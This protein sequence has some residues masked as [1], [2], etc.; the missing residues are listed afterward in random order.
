[1][2]KLDYA[3]VYTA[4]KFFGLLFVKSGMLNELIKNVP[5]IT[6]IQHNPIYGLSNLLINEDISEAS[7]S[8]EGNIAFDGQGVIVGIIGTGIDYLN[9]RFMKNTG[10][11]KIVAIWDQSIDN[12]PSSD[13]IPFGRE[14]NEEDINRAINNRAEG[15]DPYEVVPHKDEVGHGTAIAG[16]I[17]GRNFGREDKLK[18][19]APNCEFAIVKL[20]EAIPEITKLA[21]F[22]EDIKNLYLS[23]SIALAI[24]YLSDLQLKLKKLMVVYLP[25][26]TNFG[27]HEG[28]TILERYIEDITQRRDF[29][30]V[31]DTGDQGTGRTHTSGIIEKIGDTKDILFNIGQGQNSL[32]IGVYVRRIDAISISITAPSGDT[33]KNIPL[34]TVEEKNNYFN[35]QENNI[36]INYFANQTLTGLV[37]INIVIKNA[38]EGVW[39][40]SLLGEVIVSGLYDAWMPQAELL[41]GNTGFLNPVSNTTLLTPCAA[42]DIISTSYYNQIDNTV[43]ETS[44]KGYPRNGKIEPS[45]TIGGVNILTVGLNNSLVLGTGGAMAGAILAGAVALIY[46]WGIVDGNFQGLFPPR[47]KNL[48]IAST[49]KDEGK[50]YP[51]TEWGFGKL[52]FDALFETLFIT[53]NI[54]ITNPKRILK[55]EGNRELYVCIP[56]EIYRRLKDNLL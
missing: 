22:E 46:Q 56:E 15:K 51:N 53:S 25:L 8:Y 2:D 30:I 42:L 17:G 27:G 35:F 18:S 34:P 36:D 31:T 12:G 7:G 55:D 29:A 11:T 19:I 48:L 43:I 37:G 39:K 4:E 16:I 3:D 44:G 47:I 14:F 10:E 9:P 1:M 50:V 45:V 23:T 24:R 33:I 40:V 21:G 49:V 38:T 5:E 13:L 41:K 54:N 6:N 52:S 20:R 28:S 32:I 26:G